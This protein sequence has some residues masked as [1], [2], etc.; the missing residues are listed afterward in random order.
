MPAQCWQ[1]GSRAGI[2]DGA[3]AIRLEQHRGNRAGA[4]E[5]VGIEKG[6]LQHV[7]GRRFGLLILPHPTR[8]DG[9][10]AQGTERMRLAGEVRW[11]R[12]KA[13]SNEDGEQ[14][15]FPPLSTLESQVL[16]TPP[17]KSRGII[18]FRKNGE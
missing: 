11:Q 2:E 10:C 16:Q 8:G 17:S 13:E 1:R 6:G 18:N 9:K 15:V 4:A 12:W 5:P 7:C 3:V 14:S